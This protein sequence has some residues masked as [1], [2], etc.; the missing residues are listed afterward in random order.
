[1][2]TLRLVLGDQLCLT[3]SSLRDMD[4]ARD[5]VFMAEVRDKTRYAPHHKQKLVL[6]LSAMRHFADSLRAEGLSLDKVS[7]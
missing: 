6:V 2:K 5:V 4:H 1:M 3:I 7:T